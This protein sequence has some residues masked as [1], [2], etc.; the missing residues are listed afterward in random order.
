[1]AK[2][3]P[4]D[5]LNRQS[6][7]IRHVPKHPFVFNFVV[8][9]LREDFYGQAEGFHIHSEKIMPFQR[10]RINVTGGLLPARTYL[11]IIQRHIG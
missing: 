2:Q 8:A 5:S 6:M 1:M 10:E 11:S 7:E 3:Q 4:L 9:L